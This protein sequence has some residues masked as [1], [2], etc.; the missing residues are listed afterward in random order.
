VP[1]SISRGKT[2]GAD[3][4]VRCA[5]V[6]C[7]HLDPRIAALAST[8]DHH[9]LEARPSSASRSL[10]ARQHGL[11]AGR[12]WQRQRQRQCAHHRPCA[13]AKGAAAA[14][15][16]QSRSSSGRCRRSRRA[17]SPTRGTP[18]RQCVGCSVTTAT[19]AGRDECGAA[20]G[21]ASGDGPG[22]G[23]QCARERVS[24][25]SLRRR[26]QQRDR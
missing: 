14:S 16:K 4:T 24:G 7:E 2:G 11:Y 25:A 8:P 21:T 12:Q 19:A 15:Y 17:L 1:A 23:Q 6:T 9:H 10:C 26:G 13:A 18:H 20:H 3:V 5:R 22:C